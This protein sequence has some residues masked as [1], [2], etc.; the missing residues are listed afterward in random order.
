M[1][2][3]RIF[4]YTGNKCE[5]VLLPAHTDVRLKFA[6]KPLTYWAWI[7]WE[8]VEASARLIR[9]FKDF[10]W[11]LFA[12]VYFISCSIDEGRFLNVNQ[13]LTWVCG[14][15]TSACFKTWFPLTSLKN[16]T[17]T[18]KHVKTSY[19]KFHCIHS[20]L[21]SCNTFFQRAHSYLQ[22]FERLPRRLGRLVCQCQ[23]TLNETV[24]YSKREKWAVLTLCE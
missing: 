1:S 16:V 23:R 3:L 14:P 7:D 5:H 10:C 17:W 9:N 20:L 24:L 2:C 18:L 22:G 8:G 13:R 15:F 21:L 12:F 4:F 19:F 11:L 6:Y